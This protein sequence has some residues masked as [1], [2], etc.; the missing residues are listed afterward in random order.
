MKISKNFQMKYHSTSQN[1]DV[2]R[3]KTSN[4]LQKISP[5]QNNSKSFEEISS[6]IMRWILYMESDMESLYV[7]V[8]WFKLYEFSFLQFEIITLLIPLYVFP[9]SIE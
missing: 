1:W 6:V 7:S 2:E 8:Q 4:I 3:S 5:K 9:L